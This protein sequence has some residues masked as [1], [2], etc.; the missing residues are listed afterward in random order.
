[1]P[2]EATVVA[3]AGRALLFLLSLLLS[4]C[5]KDASASLTA[6]T[7]WAGTVRLVGE[8]WSRHL[9]PTPYTRRTLEAAEEGIAE[10]GKDLAQS[11]DLP[12]AD[13]DALVRETGELLRGVSAARQAVARED[14]G[15]LTAA[16]ARLAAGERS[17]RA[18]DTG[19]GGGGR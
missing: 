7:S 9:V 3:A 15:T 1:M 4:A 14:R 16:L 13:R 10:A 2:R 11:D 18:K 6:I 5:S 8:S 19:R 12:R 17:L